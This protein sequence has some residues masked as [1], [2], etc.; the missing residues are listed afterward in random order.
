MLV[1]ISECFSRV[2]V[3]VLFRFPKSLIT[4]FKD[5]LFGNDSVKT[6]HP[7]LA[8]NGLDII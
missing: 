6:P 3:S 5:R 2:R 8:G 4:D 1:V 7:A